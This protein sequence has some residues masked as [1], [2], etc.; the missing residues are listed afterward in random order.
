MGDKVMSE[1]QVWKS[2]SILSSKTWLALSHIHSERLVS[3][4][5]T[6]CYWLLE[7]NLA[8]RQIR[9]PQ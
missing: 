3:Q 9:N 7:P 2:T 6:T 4:Q 5:E 1:S 8:E